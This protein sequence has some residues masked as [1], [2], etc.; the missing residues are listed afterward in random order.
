MIYSHPLSY[1]N[2]LFRDD[3]ISYIEKVPYTNR[4]RSLVSYRKRYSLAYLL[5][6][7]ILIHGF[8]KKNKRT[9]KTLQGL[10]KVRVSDM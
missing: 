3:M 6:Q 8:F 9:I 1:L 2:S 10:L 5:Y 7:I 4:N